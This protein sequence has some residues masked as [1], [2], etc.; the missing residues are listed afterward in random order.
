M[1]NKKEK[2]EK[3]LNEISVLWI[4]S[5]SKKDLFTPYHTK[6]N[7]NME[8]NGI[9]HDFTYQC[10]L[11]YT[12][13]NK[14]DLIACVLSDARCYESCK[15]NDDD[16]ENMQEFALELGYKNNLKEL[17]KAYN[18]CKNAYN[19][20]KLMFTEEE[21]NMLEEYFQEEGLL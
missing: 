9:C 11:Q 12:K 5:N 21:K 2:L 14:N 16:T 19:I 6:F 3:L 20:I 4:K 10:N 8:Y 18:G 7:C 17:F 1:E 15:I 13:P